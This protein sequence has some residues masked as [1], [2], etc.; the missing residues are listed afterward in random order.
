MSKE[1]LRECFRDAANA[2]GLKGV[3]L[4][5]SASCSIVSR[6][7]GMPTIHIAYDE[8]GDIAHVFCEIGHVPD[9]DRDLYR[10]FLFDNLFRERTR[11]AVFAASRETG[12]IVLQRAVAVR[13]VAD[14]EAF[15][16]VLADFV[17]VAYHACRKIFRSALS[18]EDDSVAEGLAIH[19]GIR[20]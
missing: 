4:D 19:N 14:G 11:G 3:E 5:E 2:L 7:I 10:E 18:A 12:R 6:Q 15:A 20:A 16:D 8:K 1:K 17:E 9:D 13:D